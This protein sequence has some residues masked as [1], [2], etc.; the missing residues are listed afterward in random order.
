M[1]LENNHIFQLFG[2][3]TV[4]Q[5]HPMEKLLKY[6]KQYAKEYGVSV[7]IGSVIMFSLL[8]VASSFHA[9]LILLGTLL[10]TSTVLFI[11]W[12]ITDYD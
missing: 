2:L 3:L 6:I 5:M 7:L 10:F 12:R 4:Q 8:A 9:F 1:T 11:L